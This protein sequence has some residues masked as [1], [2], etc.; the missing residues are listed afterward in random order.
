MLEDCLN[1][2]TLTFSLLFFV[3]DCFKRSLFDANGGA[4]WGIGDQACDSFE[5]FSHTSVGAV[6]TPQ[7]FWA[8]TKT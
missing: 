6:V 2:K 8:P 7:R 1:K 4:G 5:T 3:M